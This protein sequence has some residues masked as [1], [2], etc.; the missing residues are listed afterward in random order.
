[1]VIIDGGH[2][3]D[4]ARADTASAPRLVSP[5]GLVNWDDYRIGWPGVVRAVDESGL[6]IF[7]LADTDL[8]VYEVR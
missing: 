7:R 2:E 5:G 1:M 3:Y 4:S 6:P 8:A